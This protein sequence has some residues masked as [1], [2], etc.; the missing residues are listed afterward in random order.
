MGAPVPAPRAKRGPPM[1]LATTAPPK[2][3][4]A[5]LFLILDSLVFTSGN[6]KWSW[7]PWWPF[8][9]KFQNNIKKF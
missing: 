1:A 5:A 7:G 4:T 6:L 8:L 2:R 3:R 9:N